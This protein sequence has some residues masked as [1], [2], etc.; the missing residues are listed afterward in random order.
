MNY[1]GANVF[2]NRPEL[3]SLEIPTNVHTINPLGSSGLKSITVAEENPTYRSQNN[4]I[5]RKD[6]KTLVLGI[7]DCTIPD[8]G[9]VKAIEK[10]AFLGNDDITAV[11]VPSSVERIGDSA[12]RDCSNLKSVML[13]GRN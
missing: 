1:I 7:S 6:D 9:S 5:I 2:D 8:D 11:T 12:F 10:N 4:C 13:F 3:T